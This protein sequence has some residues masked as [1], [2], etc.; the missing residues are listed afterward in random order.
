MRIKECF[1]IFF[2]STLSV[3]HLHYAVT[4]LNVIMLHKSL[5]TALLNNDAHHS[6]FSAGLGA[7]YETVILFMLA[8]EFCT[9][10]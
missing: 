6:T 3:L 9:D 7:L 10:F 2:L 4:C 8:S 1:L 5:S